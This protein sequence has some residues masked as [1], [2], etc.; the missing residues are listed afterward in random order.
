MKQKGLNKKIDLL[1]WRYMENL[2]TN[3]HLN[4]F[5]NKYLNILLLD[6]S[7]VFS[8]ARFTQSKLEFNRDF[9]N[10]IL[11]NTGNYVAFKH[12]EYHLLKLRQV[13]DVRNWLLIDTLLVRG[14]YM[15]G[16][17]DYCLC[18]LIFYLQVNKH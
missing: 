8:K 11:V 4:Q 2:K 13:C 12:R 9:M 17:Y 15:S 6:K 1:T 7:L 18:D 14:I 5:D 10:S 16:E 3:M